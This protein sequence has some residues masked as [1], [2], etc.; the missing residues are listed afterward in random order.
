MEQLPSAEDLED[1]ED[2]LFAHPPRQII[3]WY[4]ACGSD[5]PCAEVQWAHLVKGLAEAPR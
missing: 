4:C 5:Y 1:A 3:R 2:I